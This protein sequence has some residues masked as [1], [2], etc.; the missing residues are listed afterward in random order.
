VAV[1]GVG[2]EANELCAALGEL[3]LKLRESSQL[4]GA[5][6]CVV[7]GMRE[8][9]NPFVTDELVEV[10]GALGSLGLEVGGGAAQAERLGAFRHI[11]WSPCQLHANS[12]NMRGSGV[13][14]AQLRTLGYVSWSTCD[15]VGC[16]NQISGEDDQ[17]A[18]AFG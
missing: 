2:G 12:A 1:D 4:R 9:D 5:D 10:D 18:V 13:D 6:G 14:S 11:S 17:V 16:F 8:E 3:W 15:V 7:L